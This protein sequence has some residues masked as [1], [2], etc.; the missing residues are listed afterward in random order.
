MKIHIQVNV[1]EPKET[2]VDIVDDKDTAIKRVEQI[3]RNGIWLVDGK[4]D[5]FYPQHSIKRISYVS[6]D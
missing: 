2:V 6:V 1:G 4:F 5:R 3:A